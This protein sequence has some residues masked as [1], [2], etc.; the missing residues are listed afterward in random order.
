MADF[1]APPLGRD[2]LVLF[3]EKLDQVIP[4]D[5]TTISK[6]R[7]KNSAA[8][9]DLF[10]QIPLAAELADVEHRRDQVDAA[11]AEIERSTD[12]GQKVPARLPITDPQSRVMPNKEG[13]FA[14]NYTPTAAVDVD[15]GIIVSAGVIANSDEDK[16]MLSAVAH[17]TMR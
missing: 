7:Q 2:Q 9:K 5:H 17:V 4:P 8:L 14:P 15:S 1:A 6:F 12:E 10:V 16:Q 13:G 3:P 11:L